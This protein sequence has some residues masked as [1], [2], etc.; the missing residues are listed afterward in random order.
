MSS[1]R[2]DRSGNGAGFQANII[3]SVG[4]RTVEQLQVRAIGV[5][6]L[7]NRFI[8]RR[9]ASVIAIGRSFDRFAKCMQERRAVIAIE[10]IGRLGRREGRL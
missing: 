10:Q 1:A 2:G 3:A 8:A 5:A 4:G 7:T 9:I 6:D